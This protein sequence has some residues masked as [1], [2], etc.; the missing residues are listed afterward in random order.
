MKGVSNI[1]KPGKKKTVRTGPDSSGIDKYFVF[2]V[3]F[4][5]AFLV[6]LLFYN[7][8]FFYQESRILFIFS[9]E[10][11]TGFASKP[12]GMLEYAGN[13]LSQGYFNNIYGAFLQASVFTLI[14]AVFLR[15]NNVL[16][17]GRSFS[18]FFAALASFILMLMQTNI[19]YRLHNNLGFFVTGVYFLS[20]ISSGKKTSRILV[21]AFVPL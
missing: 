13:F 20:A 4:T 3:I 16:L 5:L 2:V 6:F 19:N 12:G 7:Y 17:P 11:L 14:A 21:T 9:G 15:I 10:Y 1:K 18:L 8:I